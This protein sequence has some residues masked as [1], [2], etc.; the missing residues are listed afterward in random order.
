[1][2]TLKINYNP[3]ILKRDL[4]LGVAWEILAIATLFLAKGNYWLLSVNLILATLYH[5]RFVYRNMKPYLLIE[6]GVLTKNS[7]PKKSMK[8]CDITRIKKFGEDFELETSE[9]KIKINAALI[10]PVS[11]KV[12]NE[13]LGGIELAP[14]L[15]PF[16]KK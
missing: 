8:L 12:L 6:N 16:S 15:T 5:G 4:Y 9:E 14:N 1:M 13:F 2:S 10:A 11:L 7:F 3:K